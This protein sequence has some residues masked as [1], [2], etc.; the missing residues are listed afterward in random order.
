M[1]TSQ[2]DSTSSAVERDR[3]LLADANAAGGWRKY[4]TYLGLS[5][6]GWI[7]SA[8]TLGGGSLASSLF[9]GVLGGYS[10]LWL[11]PLAMALGIVMMA[12]IGYVTLS[13]GE[14][15]FGAIN[16]HVNPVLGWGWALAVALANVIFC[17]PQFSLA[18]SVL[19]QNLLPAGWLQHAGSPGAVVTW[20]TARLGDTWVAAHADQLLV[21][22]VILLI[23]TMVTWSY[24]RGGWGIRLYEV[25]LK[26]IVAIIVLCFIGVVLRLTFAAGTLDWRA[27]AK[28][29]IPDFGQFWRPAATFGPLLDAIGPAGDP[30]REYWTAQI[31]SEQRDVIISAAATAVG[32]NMTF[33]FPYT[34]LRRGWTKEFRGLAIF[35]LATGMFIPFVLATSCVVIASAAQFHTQLPVGFTEERGANGSAVLVVDQTS[36]FY[37][38]FEAALATRDKELGPDA[39]PAS[40][41]EK[42]VAATLMRRDAI[43]LAKSLEPL[44]GPFVANIVFGLGVLGMVLSTISILML[45]SGF[46]FAEM[47]GAEPGGWGHR[48]GTLVAGVGGALWPVFLDRPEPVLPGRGHCR[49]RVHAVAVCVRDVRLPAQFAESVEGRDADGHQA[50]AVECA[51]GGGGVRGHGCRTVHDLGQGRDAG[52]RVWYA[53]APVRRLR[54]H[55]RVRL[56]GRVRLARPSSA[57]A[58]DAKRRQL[59]SWPVLP[60]RR[61]QPSVP[62]WHCPLP[63]TVRCSQ[64][65]R[66]SA[67]SVS[68]N[69]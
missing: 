6:P 64:H 16:Q 12:A 22:A 60:D 32:I 11:Q 7:A 68:Q 61:P 14:R 35:D 47:F 65:T 21:S 57:L 53:G 19:S 45:I 26:S 63:V 4:R 34:L 9:L 18:Q 30:A 3:R 40:D 37:K 59:R 56:A 46:V 27:V 43:D 44:T 69:D 38:P 58:A 55:W 8:I 36:P 39:P 42:T 62:K 41:A 15:P 31:V 48:A 20:A 17:M 49:V 28:G 10:L 67:Q 33:M 24:D 66:I 50:I 29:W 25:V 13:T 23:T 2:A 54:C 5:G 1:T 52:R 51:D